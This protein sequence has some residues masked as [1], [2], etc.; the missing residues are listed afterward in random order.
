MMPPPNK[1][2]DLGLHSYFTLK[3]HFNIRSY[4]QKQLETTTKKLMQGEGM[5]RVET[6]EYN[7]MFHLFQKACNVFGD[8]SKRSIMYFSRSSVVYLMNLSP[9]LYIEAVP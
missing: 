8:P 6:K 3:I 9:I 4:I 5:L 1:S 2:W 7:V